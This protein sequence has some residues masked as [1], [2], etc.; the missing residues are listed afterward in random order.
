VWQLNPESGELRKVLQHDAALFTPGAPGFLTKD[1]ESSGIVPLDGI[2]GTDQYLLV[3]Q[4][5]L[6]S[7]DPELVEG[8]QFL[9]VT[10]PGL[11]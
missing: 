1:E 6:A 5:H 8:G 2:L 3:D 4:V 9:T 7:A 10:I 11:R